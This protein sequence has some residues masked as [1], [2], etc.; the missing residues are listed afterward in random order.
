MRNLRYTFYSLVMKLLPI[1]P[2][3][4]FQERILEIVRGE[5][6][7]KRRE[8]QQVR[9][10]ANQAHMELQSDLE[11]PDYSPEKKE[12]LRKIDRQLCQLLDDYV[13]ISRYRIPDD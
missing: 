1:G 5:V 6:E 8:L 10:Q 13:L 9:W 11:N 2:I 3:R 4:P 7:Q 12:E